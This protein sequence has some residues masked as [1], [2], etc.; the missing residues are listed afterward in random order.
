[1]DI[2]TVIPDLLKVKI[3]E[4]QTLKTITDLSSSYSYG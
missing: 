3:I 2:P 4:T 1:M